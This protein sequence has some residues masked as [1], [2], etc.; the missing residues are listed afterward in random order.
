M[1][2]L[3]ILI[4]LAEEKAW[5]YDDTGGARATITCNHCSNTWPAS[6]PWPLDQND[7]WGEHKSDC[8]L[9]QAID[10]AKSFVTM[11]TAVE[12]ARRN[13]SPTRRDHACYC[14]DYQSSGMPCLPGQCP[15]VPV[16]QEPHTCFMLNDVC[17]AQQ[18]GVCPQHSKPLS[19]KQCCQEPDI[20][21]N[22]L[23]H[24]RGVVGWHQC[25]SCKF[26][27]CGRCKLRPVA[28]SPLSRMCDWCGI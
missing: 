15:N 28:E 6:R 4:E 23:Y 7:G 20:Y 17:L 22:G 27:L 24:F 10:H 3:E 2:W 14:S 1:K 9:K 8:E 11:A 13:S 5:L 16:W 25:R 26:P 18:G 21:F 12:P 19:R